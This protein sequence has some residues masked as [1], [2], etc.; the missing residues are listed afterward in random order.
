[1]KT[2]STKERVVNSWLLGSTYNDHKQVTE[3]SHWSYI[4]N[5]VDVTQD[6]LM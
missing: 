4:R 2:N 5:H 1:M 3:F 6:M